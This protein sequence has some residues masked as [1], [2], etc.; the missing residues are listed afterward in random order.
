MLFSQIKFLIRD[1][2]Q[3]LSI[4]YDDFIKDLRSNKNNLPYHLIWCAGLPK[5]GTTLIEEIINILPYVQLNISPLRNFKI[6]QLDHE[7]GINENMFKSAPKNKY[8][9]L[10]TH[11]HYK[12]HYE[13]IA[14]DFNA[15]IIVSVR[16]LRD[17]MISRYFHILSDEKHW[18]HS[19]IK[20][21]PFHD[22]FL[23]SLTYTTSSHAEAPIVYFYNWI[24]DWTKVARKANYLLLWYEDYTKDPIKYINNILNYI[25][26]SKKSPE[27]IEMKLKSS[28]NSKKKSLKEN[29]KKYGKLQSTYRKAE[30]NQWKNLF[31]KEIQLSFNNLLP[32]SSENVLYKG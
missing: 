30:S 21:L 28:L 13:K 8:S 1:P 6:G 10:K 15:R 4:F 11:T 7:H 25:K 27:E 12:K 3:F 14:N 2:V 31:T 26:F 5:S 32:G 20:D 23:K 16:D 22:G 19:A 24:N 18:Q 9:F 17:V 29:L